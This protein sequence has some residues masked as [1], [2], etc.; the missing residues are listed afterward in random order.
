MANPSY[1][2]NLKS[3][4]SAVAEILKGNPQI[5]GSSPAHGHMHFFFCWDLMMGLGNYG[6][7]M[8]FVLNDK[9]TF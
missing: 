2:P 3:L 5:C 1:I 8:E 4:T 7:I 9:F 6:N